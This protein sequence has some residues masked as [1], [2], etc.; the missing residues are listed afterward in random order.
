M[1]N[2]FILILAACVIGFFGILFFTKKDSSKTD[3]GSGGQNGSQLTQHTTGGGKT[4]VVLV[5]YGDFECPACY[6]FYPIIEQ[7]KE[8]YKDQITFQFRHFPLVEIHKNALIASRAAEAAG[9]QGKFFDMYS[10]L[11]INHQSWTTASD[12]STYFQQYAK[13]LGLDEAKFKSDMLSEEV[14]KSVQADKN[15]A[16]EQGFN[17]TPT[18]VL[19][20]KKLEDTQDTVEYFSQK[21]DEAIAQKSKNGQ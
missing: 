16:K 8:K 10:K 2:R 19:D 21:I 1:N 3:G 11:Y 7:V 13:E 6:R 17:S 5:E 18:F 12:P 20:G 14:N 9:K 4:G 15:Y